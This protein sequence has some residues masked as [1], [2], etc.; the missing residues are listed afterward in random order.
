MAAAA[1]ALAAMSAGAA[2]QDYPTRPVTLVAPFPPGAV[3]DSMARVLQTAI[4]GPLGQPIV[5]DNRA[6]AGGVLGTN[7]M[8]RSKP[9]GYTLLLTVNAPVVMSPFIQA[10]FPFDPRTGIAGVAKVAETYLTLAV[11]KDSPLNSVAD[12]IRLAKEKPEGSLT[13]GSAGVGSA[14]QIAG[15]LLNKNAGIKITHVPFQGGAPAI[16]NLIG[17]HISMSYGTLPAVLPFVDSGQ[18]KLIA[19]AEPKRIPELPNVPAMN[20]TVPGVE[21]TTW[22]GV[23]APAGTPKAIRDRLYALIGDA[24]KKPE[25]I[26]KMKSLGMNVSLEGPEAFDATIARDLVFWK[27]AID[28][29]GMEK[30]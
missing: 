3:T 20:E 14:H 24:L 12:V 25:V 6:G 5:I 30:R 1:F 17:G 27:G 10:N 8:V 7:F 29:I 9:D 26:A 16:Q 11:Q 4:E 18:L 2:A 22:V 19:A 13:F 28:K 15:E 23:F 21:T